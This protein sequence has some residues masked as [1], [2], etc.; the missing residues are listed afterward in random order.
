MTDPTERSRTDWWRLGAVGVTAV[1]L[2]LVGFS[3]AS[4]Y[5]PSGEA[6]TPITDGDDVTSTSAAPTTT[7]VSPL[8]VPTE[9]TTTTTVGES[10]PAVIALSEEVLDF[11]EDQDSLQ[12]ELTHVQ[13]SSTEWELLAN[14]SAVSF[15]PPGGDIAPGE[16][17]PVTVSL[18]RTQMGEGE[19]E[20]LLTLRWPEGEST[21]TV[22]AVSEDNPIIHNP[23]VTPSTLQVG[24]GAECSPTRATVSARVRDTSEIDQVI[25]R[26]SP[27]GS[28]TR[29]TAMSP[30]GDDIYEGVIGPYEATG[31]D[32]VK[33]VAFDVRGNAGGASVSVAVVACG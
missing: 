13:G 32:S 22:V 8:P 29:E 18:D 31:S 15:D 30:A 26:W 9:Q 28:A 6:L 23:Q 4:R 7:A 2:S 25:A 33:V 24:S 16:T 11:A 12:V 20:V 1:L 21:A 3:I 27:D 10:E 5:Q 14:E 17:V 19:L